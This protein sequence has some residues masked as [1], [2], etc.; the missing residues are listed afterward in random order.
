MWRQYICPSLIVMQI[1]RCKL[2]LKPLVR[3]TRC[4]QSKFLSVACLLTDMYRRNS[5]GDTLTLLLTNRDNW[6]QSKND[7]GRLNK[8]I[9]PCGCINNLGLLNDESLCIYRMRLSPTFSMT[10]LTRFCMPFQ[11]DRAHA[12]FNLRYWRDWRR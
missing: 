7:Y 4:S 1:T 9:S 12:R 6:R 3:E 10:F 8:Q 5:C 2:S 11:A